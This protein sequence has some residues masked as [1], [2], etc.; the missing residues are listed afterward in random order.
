MKIIG[1]TGGIGSG[2]TT[3]SKEFIDNSI[4]VY[5][6]DDRAKFL[7]KN[8]KNIKNKLL[9]S[10]GSEIFLSGSLNKPYISKLIFSDSK[11]LNLINSIVHPEVLKDFIDWKSNLNDKYIIYESA[12][13]FETGSYK[14]NDFNILV[15]SELNLRINRIVKRDKL[16]KEMVI[17]KIQSQWD[18]EKKIPLAD[19]VFIN[20]SK[21]A[22][23][24]KVK[25]LITYFNSIFK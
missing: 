24:L 17:K 25:N 1:L 15:T 11:S 3:I 12:L 16:D 5:N 6:S 23:I 7:M 13:I 20:S 2:K 9:D 4:K 10:F 22:N 19:Y 8:S 21:K 18:D 14:L